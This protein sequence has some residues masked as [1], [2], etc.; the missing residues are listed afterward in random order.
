MKKV[1]VLLIYV[2][3]LSF[4]ILGKEKDEVSVFLEVELK[5][6]GYV[7]ETLTYNINLYSTSQEISDITETR[8]FGVSDFKM[9]KG[10]VER[11]SDNKVK[12]KGKQYYKWNIGRYFII[13]E[14]KGYFTVKGGEYEVF[15]PVVK[16]VEDPW[17][18]RRKSVVYDSFVLKAPDKKIKISPLPT[19]IKG[20]NFSGAVGDFS[21]VSWLPPGTISKG[22][23]AVAII[24][25]SGN[26]LL[27]NVEFPSL[28]QVFAENCK[29]KS[30]DR[31]E[32]LSQENGN[33]VS[34]VV[35][36][37]LFIP[38]SDKGETSVFQFSFFNPYTKKYQT[39]STEPQPWNNSDEYTPVDKSKLQIIEI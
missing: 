30:I 26:G 17:W 36:E 13:P 8:P 12:V 14:K 9:I 33:L 28:S 3:F 6:N 35:L 4:N 34:E 7:G 37:C 25:I 1:I 2:V 5:S 31:R 18:G 16:I 32:N 15:F 11:L 38:T 39:V 27:E 23:E 29:L 19:N 10:N 22:K 20:E 24:K 21:V